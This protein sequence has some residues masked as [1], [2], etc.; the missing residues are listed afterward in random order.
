MLTPR[1]EAELERVAELM[2]E[3]APMGRWR[4]VLVPVLEL[5]L[6]LVPS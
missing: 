1:P 5:G 2:R 6:G 3:L 4:G